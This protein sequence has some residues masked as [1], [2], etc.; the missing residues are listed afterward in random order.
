MYV[1]RLRGACAEEEM[2]ILMLFFIVSL[3]GA[4]GKISL[5]SVRNPRQMLQINGAGSGKENKV[6]SIIP[7]PT[8]IIN[9][10]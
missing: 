8:S 10:I 7:P 5:S 3:E 1:F 4:L 9:L 2:R 6:R